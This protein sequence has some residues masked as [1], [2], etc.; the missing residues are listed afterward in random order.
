MPSSGNQAG[1][2]FNSVEYT[3]ADCLS[4]WQLDKAVADIMYQC[5]GG[6]K[7]HG[8]TNGG[9]FKITLTLAK[10][11]TTKIAAM[12][13]GTTGSFLAYLG[14]DIDNLIAAASNAMV[15]SAPVSA[16]INGMVV[17]DVT[18]AIDD[19]VVTAI[20]TLSPGKDSRVHL[21]D[22]DDNYGTSW[23]LA[24]QNNIFLASRSYLYFD[25]S[26]VSADKTIRRAE[27]QMYWY[28]KTDDTLYDIYNVDAA[29]VENT[30]TWNNQ[31]GDTG[32]SLAQNTITSTGWGYDDLTAAV[33]AWHAGGTN[34]GIIL[35]TGEA[36]G[37]AAGKILARSQNYPDDVTLRP[38]LVIAA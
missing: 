1:F 30:I 33:A 37:A 28:Q 38:R 11:D 18:I 8:G 34:N 16:V 4:G 13:I 15:I 6:D 36:G 31:P 2:E 9:A 29:W 7:H 35:R 10:T 26:S 14:A 24:V 23:Y 17:M 32:A 12:R 3:A 22:P 20:S 21:S 25:I 27:L 19:L 5:G